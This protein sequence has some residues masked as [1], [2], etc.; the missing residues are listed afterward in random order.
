M[1]F[2]LKSESAAD[3]FN[4]IARA[5]KRRSFLANTWK[6]WFCWS[7]WMPD[8]PVW[9]QCGMIWK[10]RGEAGKTLFGRN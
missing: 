9:S 8:E 2:A 6:L 7:M 10:Y 5:R 4:L 1:T 3:V